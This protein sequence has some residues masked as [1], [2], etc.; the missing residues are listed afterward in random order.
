MTPNEALAA[1]LECERTG[2]TRYQLS[3]EIQRLRNHIEQSVPILR[4]AAWAADNVG[5]MPAVH[6]RRLASVAE[7]LTNVLQS[8]PFYS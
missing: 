6:R 4:S 2:T 7:R 3:L 1:E 5:K 8:S